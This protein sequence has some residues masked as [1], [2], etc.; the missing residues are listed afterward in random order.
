M[1]YTEWKEKIKQNRDYQSSGRRALMVKSLP[2]GGCDRAPVTTGHGDGKGGLGGGRRP[3]RAR[4][5]VAGARHL[6]GTAAEG[7]SLALRD[8]DVSEILRIIDSSQHD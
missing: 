3:G 1:S 7:L 6:R 5:D 2:D 4:H 8:E